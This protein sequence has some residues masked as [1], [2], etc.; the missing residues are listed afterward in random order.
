MIHFTQMDAISYLKALPNDS[1]NLL[2]TDP[3]YASLEKHR[4]VGTTA[5]LTSFFDVVPNDYYAPWIAE[6]WRVM[7]KNTHGYIFCDEET[8]DII[9]PLLVA[10]GFT[11]WK[12]IVWDKL[13][14]GMGYHYGNQHEFILFFEKG[15]RKLNHNHG[16]SVMRYK[17]VRRKKNHPH[18][19]PTE[20]NQELIEFLINNSSYPDDT[21]LDCFLGSGTTALACAA[22]NR[23]FMGCDTSERSIRL[24]A[25]KLGEI[26]HFDVLSNFEKYPNAIKTPLVFDFGLQKFA[27]HKMLN[28]PV[29]LK[30]DL[31]S[32]L[33]GEWNLQVHDLNP[34]GDQHVQDG[35]LDL[36]DLNNLYGE[37]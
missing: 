35:E 32:R 18:Y 10:Q 9:K 36:G 15:K 2:I 12:R 34:L 29:I 7:A 4:S 37:D 27:S 28:K 8:S 14:R 25:Q 5:R 1:I 31:V 3:P 17:G 11:F 6:L 20:K 13:N 30:D 33:N 24:T 22:L 21:I 26:S 19:Y 16:I 23:K